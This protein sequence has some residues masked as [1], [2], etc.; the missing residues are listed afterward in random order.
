MDGKKD[1]EISNQTT[2]E[3][4]GGGIKEVG[5]ERVSVGGRRRA[6][7]TLPKRSE[8]GGLLRG[9]GIRGAWLELREPSRGW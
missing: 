2:Q 8:S 7:E 5:G 3:G 6:E 1:E 4:G 9:L